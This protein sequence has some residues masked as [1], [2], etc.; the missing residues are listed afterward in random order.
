MF[1]PPHLP[2]ERPP[3]Q[4]NVCRSLTVV[5]DALLLFACLQSLT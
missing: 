5:S 3:E 1:F 4:D 2:A